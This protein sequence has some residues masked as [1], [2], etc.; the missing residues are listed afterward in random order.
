[1]ASGAEIRA[2]ID[3]ET[4]RALILINGGGSLALVAFLPALLA[5]AQ[6][7]P[8]MRGIFQ[9]LMLF[10]GGLL[11]AIAHNHLRRRCSAVWDVAPRVAGWVGRLC[12]EPCVCCWSHTF[13][14]L[15]AVFFTA[16]VVM[17]G[18]SASDLVASSGAKTDQAPIANCQPETT[19]SSRA[20]LRASMI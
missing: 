20:G 19:N 14:F 18:G 6:Y 11:S 17:V 9:A 15:S 2:S 1:M 8:L 4:V 12:R 10:Q 5:D 7:Q 13:M 3:N 16:A